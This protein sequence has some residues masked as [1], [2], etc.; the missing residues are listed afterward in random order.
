MSQRNLFVFVLFALASLFLFGCD[1]NGQPLD[2][3]MCSNPLYNQ[4]T[5]Q[6]CTNVRSARQI[7]FTIDECR[8]SFLG[9]FDTIECENMRASQPASGGLDLTLDDVM[10]ECTTCDT[11]TSGGQIMN[12]NNVVQEAVDA[13]ECSDQY[14]PRYYDQSCIAWQLA[15]P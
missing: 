11:A 8:N 10:P 1:E 13:I 7:V 14:N 3:E 12:P 4:F 2:P 5:S 15:N 6:A 9:A